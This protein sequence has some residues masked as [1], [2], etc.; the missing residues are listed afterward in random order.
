MKYIERPQHL[1]QIIAWARTSG[2]QFL[3]MCVCV[4]HKLGARCRPDQYGLAEMPRNPK[5][6]RGNSETFP[7]SLSDAPRPQYHQGAWDDTTRSFVLPNQLLQLPSL[8]LCHPFRAPSKAT[9]ISHNGMKLTPLLP[10]CQTPLN[11]VWNS[12]KVVFIVEPLTAVIRF[13]HERGVE[14]RNSNPNTAITPV[15]THSLFIFCV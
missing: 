5:S 11:A 6:Q 8:L 4:K 15:V 2:E 9:V 3:R 14:S 10:V 13:S 12:R 7:A 1:P